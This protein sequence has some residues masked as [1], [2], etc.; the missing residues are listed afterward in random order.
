MSIQDDRRRRLAPTVLGATVVHSDG[1]E[2]Q[3]DNMP[4]REAI[5]RWV[6]S[7][8]F[9][10]NPI[11]VVFDPRELVARDAA[12]EPGEQLTARP[13]LPPRMSPFDMLRF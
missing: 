6:R 7:G 13:P 1:V 2:L 11:G 9:C 4:S 8:E 5:D 10:A 3:V 12:G